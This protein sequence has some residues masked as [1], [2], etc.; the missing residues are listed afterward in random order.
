[1]KRV[2]M[3]K[4]SPS[5]SEGGFSLIEL[6]M[7]MIIIGVI[8][9]PLMQRFQIYQKDETYS[10]TTLALNE[11]HKKLGEYYVE[12]GYYPCP[13]NRSIAFGKP[14]HGESIA[15]CLSAVSL[16][17]CLS[18]SGA[19]HV[20]GSGG[21][22]IIG[23]IP[24]ATLNL[25]YNNTLDGYKNPINYVISDVYLDT[26]KAYDDTRKGTITLSDE[27]GAAPLVT[28]NNIYGLISSGENRKGSFN[29]NGKIEACTAGTAD[30]VNCDNNSEYVDRGA[31]YSNGAS[32][33]DD[34]VSFNSSEPAALWALSL[35]TPGG[36]YNTN[37]GSVGIGTNNPDNSVKLDVVG[38]V[39]AEQMRAQDFCSKDGKFCTQSEV[40]AGDKTKCP[41]G[42]YL[43]GIADNKPVC[44]AMSV[45]VD[46]ESCPTGQFVIGIVGGKIKCAAPSP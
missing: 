16:G 30:S 19:C 9:V 7:V 22:A 1:M 20:N 31:N 35:T 43:T 14:K 45:T 21:S 28:K 40:I 39:K 27:K 5:H 10:N 18:G 38:D 36:I 41:A 15:N 8:S 11:I 3:N 13:A 32:Y 29:V 34:R 2:M 37:A 26:A 24:Y 42:Q 6:A 46:V 4:V 17:S 23:G 12:H 25:P 44:T 33:Y